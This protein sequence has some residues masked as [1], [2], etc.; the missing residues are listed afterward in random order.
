MRIPW[1]V[2]KVA[3]LRVETPTSRTIAFDVPDWP[4]HVAG[5]HVDLR[6]T[7]EDGYSVQRSYSLAAPADDDR[8]ELTVQQVPAG[9]VSPF[10]VEDL[11]VDDEIELRGPIGGWFA[12]RPGES[13]PV[14]LVAGGSGIVPL[15]AMIRARSRAG[16]QPGFKLVYSVRAPADQY[17][18]EELARRAEQDE[19]LDVS[20]LYTRS[21]AGN[22]RPA[23]RIGPADIAAATW[24]P[25][26]G[27]RTYV[28]GPTG[29][30]EAVA[31]LLLDR[32]HDPATIRTERFGPTGG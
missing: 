5:Q 20:V 13:M 8:I 27:P 15:M 25:A 2:A 22:G 14:T 16:G 24:P 19:G 30:V 3:D 21:P 23:G 17:Y 29:F 28:C 9:E 7:A 12:W 4:G 26:A 1:L 18:A 6:L 32:G 11:L 10:L 31:K